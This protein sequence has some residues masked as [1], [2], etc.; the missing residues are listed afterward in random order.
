MEG[1]VQTWWTCIT[2]QNTLCKSG[3]ACRYQM[4]SLWVS[5]IAQLITESERMSSISLSKLWLIGWREG[6]HIPQ[7]VVHMFRTRVKACMWSQQGYTLRHV[8]S[9]VTY[10]VVAEQWP[11]WGRLAVKLHIKELL[12]R[13]AVTPSNGCQV[14]K[15]DENYWMRGNIWKCLEHH[16]LCCFGA[17][18]HP[19]VMALHVS[20]AI[21]CT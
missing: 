15:G 21:S 10:D 14:S 13:L 7:S 11:L 9:R 16:V 8:L 18:W 3:K 19:M 17:K 6:S 12:H 20:A 4:E 5:S 2:V 1:A